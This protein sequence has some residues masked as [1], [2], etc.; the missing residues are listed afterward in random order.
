MSD[1]ER[2]FELFANDH[3]LI[4]L[5]TSMKAKGVTLKDEKEWLKKVRIDYTKKKPEEYALAITANGEL[6]GGISAHHVDY[7]DNKTEMGYW[8]GEPY[9]GRGYAT[10]AVRDFTEK[11]F[12]KFKFKRIEAFPFSHNEASAR[13]LEKVGFKFEGKRKKAVKKGKK[14]LD[15]MVWAKV[16]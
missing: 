5:A 8:I 11:L 9:W 1:L 15:D 4:N 10:S 3:V 2:L 13:V 7:S 12:K 6:V 16:K 14:Y